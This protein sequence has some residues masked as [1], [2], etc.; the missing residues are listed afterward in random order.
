[1]NTSALSVLARPTWLAAS[2][3]RLVLI[4]HRRHLDG[5]DLADAS[6]LIVSTDWLAWRRAVTAGAHCLHFEFALGTWPEGRGDPATTHLRAC[7]WV[8]VDGRDVTLFQ[9]VSLGHQFVRDVTLLSNAAERLWHALDRLCA[10]F[11]PGRLELIDLRVEFD[12]LDPAVKRALVADVARRHGA[13][14]VDRLDAPPAGDPGFSE[15][16]DDYGAPPAEP[17]LGG[18]LRAIYGGSIDW[19]CRVRRLFDRRAEILILHNFATVRSLL[20]FHDS[21][22]VVP[23]LFAG[24]M[25][26]SPRFL[27][28]VLR[29]GFSLVHVPE[30][31]LDAADLR[32]LAAIKAALAAAWTAPATGVEA[33]RQAFIRDRI[34]AAGW[35]EQRARAVKGHLDLFRRR[36]FA[37]VLVG[38]AT[39]QLCRTLAET[40]RLSGVPVDELLNG[41]FLAPQVCDAR[42]GSAHATPCID[43]LLSWGE[44]NERWL[45]LSRAALPTIRTGYPALDVLRA[46]PT[47]FASADHALVLPI[48][49]DCD[50]T[51]AL[52]G[53]IF[54]WMVETVGALKAAGCRTV[55]VKLHSGPQ[56]LGYYR[57]VLVESGL[58]DTEIV[59]GGPL[60]PHLAWAD[61]VVGPVNSG[62][63]VETMAAGK[64]YFPIRP[65]PSLI[66]W[67]LLPAEG[68]VT[69]ADQLADRVARR[70][71]PDLRDW[72]AR[73]CSFDE[74]PNASRRAWRVLESE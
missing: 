51:P 61:L 32:A 33:A 15:R 1:M 6:Q 42:A 25:P 57:D 41:M 40:A 13:V 19:A 62:A 18:W 22:T 34:V 49:A 3:Q 5:L 38:D 24:H 63:F 10:E 2:Y 28:D 11:R 29:R 70:A 8:T 37:R 54:T 23:A 39:N 74:F 58:G 64:P 50:D 68:I 56:N 17:R 36:R 67:S 69:R 55:R 43:R 45:A 7:D 59:K 21:T 48:Y 66:D 9:G 27:L 71:A 12:L 44:G 16:V 46:D 26:K 53:N 60:D 65:E 4:S 73:W 14:V 47:P 20:A 35:L 52:F 72:M 31:R 30:G